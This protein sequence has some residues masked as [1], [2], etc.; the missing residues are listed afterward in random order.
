[1]LA[2]RVIVEPLGIITISLVPGTTPPTHADAELQ[3][4]E[5]VFAVIVLRT[6][7]VPLLVIVPLNVKLEFLISVPPLLIV[8]ELTVVFATKVIVEPFGIITS[9][10]VLGITEPTHA[11]VV[12]QLNEPVLAVIVLRMIIFPLFVIVPVKTVLELRIKVPPVFIVSVLTVSLAVSVIVEPLGIITLS[13]VPG[14]TPL[15]HA[16]VVFQVYEPTFAVMGYATGPTFAATKGFIVGDEVEYSSAP[17]S[18]TPLRA[19]PSIS[20]VTKLYVPSDLLIAALLL[21]LK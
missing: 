16:A 15:I 1:M 9:S 17:I 7:K 8:V 21:L 11:A 3:V 2:V 14:I 4:N 13:V 20:V 18:L 6:I 19:S 5:P 12:F 10:V